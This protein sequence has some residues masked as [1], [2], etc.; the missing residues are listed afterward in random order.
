MR[1]ILIY[2]ASGDRP[3]LDSMRDRPD[4]EVYR[5]HPGPDLEDQIELALLNNLETPLKLVYVGGDEAK[6][7]DGEYSGVWLPDRPNVEGDLL[8]FWDL[9][10]AVEP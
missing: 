8:R 10:P 5:L 4:V 9:A 6:K 1:F 2:I 3:E 7:L